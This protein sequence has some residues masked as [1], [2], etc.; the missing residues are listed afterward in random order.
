MG[1]VVRQLTKVPDA[2]IRA[3]AVYLASF[4]AA[5]GSGRQKQAK[6]I[7]AATMP[8]MPA[9]SGARI[10]DGSCAVCHQP[11]RGFEMFGVRPSLA[12]NSNIHSTRPDNLIRVI[13]E[14]IGVP[15]HAEL[16]AMPSFRTSLD[17]GQLVD[18]VRYLRGQFAPDK[19]EW[20]EL[21]QTVARMRKSVE[22]VETAAAQGTR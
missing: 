21:E 19:P 5:E 1:D 22:E 8:A 15:A 11:G 18:L 17:D 20:T 6:D 3:M 13:L 16:G 9:G 12:V 2:D 14:G 7:E 10:Y 4:G